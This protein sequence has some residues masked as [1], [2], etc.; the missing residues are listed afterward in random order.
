[1]HY[2]LAPLVEGEDGADVGQAV[3]VAPMSLFLIK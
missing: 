3:A 1:M 2:N